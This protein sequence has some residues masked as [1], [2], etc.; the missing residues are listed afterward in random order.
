MLYVMLG[1]ATA[2]FLMLGLAKRLP[3]PYWQ[4]LLQ[5]QEATLAI[6][7]FC[8][9]GI[10]MRTMEH[11]PTV[12][13]RGKRY[14]LIQGRR[15]SW[16]LMLALL[17]SS[18][19]FV[20]RFASLRAYAAYHNVPISEF[21]PWQQRGNLFCIT[22]ALIS[23]TIALAHIRDSALASRLIAMAVAVASLV[24]FAPLLMPLG[25][26][27]QHPYSLLLVVVVGLLLYLVSR[28]I[29]RRWNVL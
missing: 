13:L 17:L 15:F 28:V 25:Y 9:L 12:T 10:F 8:A 26:L 21:D 7:L 14:P 11:P 2:T 3:A 29:Q 23:G 27:P 24:S 5:A 4:W 1:S 19:A 6:F 16:K 18:A 22:L 20:Y